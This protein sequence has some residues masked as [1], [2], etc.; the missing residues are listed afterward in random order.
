MLKR[1]VINNVNSIKTCEIDFI[2]GNYKFS[3]DN[4]LGS[5]VNPI[6]IY[7]HN[8]SGKSSLLNAVQHF[9]SLMV[10]P[11][12]SLMPFTVNNFLFEQFRKVEEEMYLQ[13]DIL[14]SFDLGDKSYEYYLET[15][16]FDNRISKE[17][18]KADG[19]IYFEN[20]GGKYRYQ[21]KGY[22]PENHQISKMVPLIRILGS[23]EIVDPIV[24]T[25]FAYF[26]SFTHV[27]VSFINRGAF[28]TSS[29]FNNT[30]IFDLLT[31]KSDEVKEVLK[32][33]DN[34]PVYS[35]VKDDKLL[36]NGFVQPQY[37]VVLEDDGFK[38][39]LPFQMISTGMQNQSVLL[40]LVL[41]MPKN[42]VLFID[43]LD[44]ALHPSA[45]QSF[46]EVI[47]KRKVQVV[48]TLHNTNAMQYLRPDQIYFAK[49][50][51][52]FSTY[53]RLSKIYPNIREVNNIEKMYLSTLFDGA[54][55]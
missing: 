31:G 4:V 10:L 45:L 41:S 32:E 47:K 49:W 25:V 42:S 26:R 50:S 12:E 35:I 30:N 3:E 2:K 54:M 52:G 39:K 28:V 27:N 20:E 34:F 17:Y 18:L 5:L 6:A 36:P 44:I 8:G 19:E 37:N 43:E 7:G 14:L 46:I 40:S 11:T 33:Y 51:K 38:G 9:I 29:I 21:G 48:V 23:S 13:G 24:Q 22:R 15:S 16:R 55:E 1:I 53:H